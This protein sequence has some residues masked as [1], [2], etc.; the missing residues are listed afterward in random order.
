MCLTQEHNAVTPSSVSKDSLR[1]TCVASDKLM[2]L[3]VVYDIS[4][5]ERNKLKI[6]RK[7]ECFL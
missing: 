5:V 4:S 6:Q 3:F 2:A 1:Y 7:D